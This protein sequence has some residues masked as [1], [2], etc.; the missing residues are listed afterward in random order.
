MNTTDHLPE[1][2]FTGQIADDQFYFEDIDV[3]HPALDGRMNFG[4][5]GQG[6]DF[7]AILIEPRQLI[8]LVDGEASLTVIL[9]DNVMYSYKFD[10][11]GD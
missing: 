2:T 4:P 11:T 5:G 3:K 10:N 6:N 8:N 7:A 1:Q 9:H